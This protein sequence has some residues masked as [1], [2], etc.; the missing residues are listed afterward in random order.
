MGFC[1]GRGQRKGVDDDDNTSVLLAVYRD[2]LHNP[3]NTNE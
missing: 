2:C 1:R 3:I